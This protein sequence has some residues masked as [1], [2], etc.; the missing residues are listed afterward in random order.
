MLENSEILFKKAT[1]LIVSE[2]EEE[3]RLLAK[4][5]FERVDHFKSE[6][7]AWEY[8]KYN[9]RKLENYDIII[10]GS[11]VTNRYGSTRRFEFRKRID[12]LRSRGKIR[13]YIHWDS[14]TKTWTADYK[15][16]RISRV[17][18]DR[19]T[20]YIINSL[21]A[22]KQFMYEL[23]AYY[24][25]FFAINKGHRSVS[26]TMQ[27]S[28]LKI[29]FCH[30]DNLKSSV[31]TIAQRLGLDV[32]F[33][34]EGARSNELI[35][36]HLG[37]YDIIIGSE[38]HS[39]FLNGAFIESQE[40]CSRTGR[41]VSLIITY[42]NNVCWSVLEGEAEH[43]LG[44]A[45]VSLKSMRSGAISVLRPTDT[46][47][48]DFRLPIVTN[49]DS[50]LEERYKGY[51]EKVIQVILN[52]SLWLYSYELIR[53]Y[54]TRLIGGDSAR[55]ANY[56]DLFYERTLRQMQE[57]ISKKAEPLNV[58]KDIERMV[59]AY[60]EHQQMSSVLD[61]QRDIRIS[62]SREG[63]RVDILDKGRFTK[64]SLTLSKNYQADS[65]R[66]VAIRKADMKK[67]RL[68]EERYILVSLG[69][70]ADSQTMVER[71]SENDIVV[72]KLIRQMLVE[73]I[74]PVI[75]SSEGKLDTAVVKRHVIQ[76]K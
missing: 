16:N 21:K 22:D 62:E 15:N 12:E 57:D 59:K 33:I 23:E 63:Y 55:N 27:Q 17:S 10:V 20:N 54:G 28:K 49:K 38:Q 58:I 1:V 56:Y 69:L 73:R 70:S 71:A 66:I 53:L 19:A 75:S 40:Q 3:A 68:G 61:R 65:Y 64:Y 42:E 4:R 29:L 11:L 76:P 8:F 41:G 50:S 60:C 26:T 52:V 13:S 31:K 18:F 39:S 48:T 5:G 67:H 37:D 36:P 46:K 47:S 35:L 44:R 2:S 14:I 30:P 51:E 9:K 43:S 6:I 72:I 34:R 45:D 32:T 7:C 25:P 74:M 24:R